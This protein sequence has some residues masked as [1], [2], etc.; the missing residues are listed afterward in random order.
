M[1][2][3]FASLLVAALFAAALARATPVT[4]TPVT[5]AHGMVVAAHPQA[6]AAGV[7]ILK[8]GGNA[9]DAAVAVAL[10]VGV[11]EPYGSGLGGK[12]MLVYYDAKSRTTTVVEAMDACG[13]ALDPDAYRKLPDDARS[14]G[15][16]SVC[17]PGLAAGLWTMHQKWGA[18]K[19]ADTVAPAIALARDG[20][21]IL[22][23]SRD[24]F[25]EQTKKLHRGDAELARLYLVDG[26]LPAV[27][28]KLK[29]ADLAHTMELLAAHG[30]DG[31][32]RGE[33]AE[34]IVAAAQA[35]GGLLTLEDFAGYEARLVAPLT[36]EFRG[37]RLACAPPPAAGPALFLTIMKAVET[38]DFGAGPLRT[39]ENLDRLGRVW[40]VAQPLA[41]KVVGDDPSSRAAVEK[42]FAPASI[43]SIRE[44][45]AASTP[46]KTVW[47][48]DPFADESQMAATTH[49][50][51][52]DAQGNI[53]CGTQSQSLHFGAGVIPPGTGV[54]LNDSM[55]NFSLTDPKS[56]NA[57]AVGRRPR[58][59]ISPTI[60]FRGEKPAFAIG[61]PGAARIPT[62]M[63]QGLLD[64]L[65][66]E[67]P[68]AEAIGDTRW[69]FSAPLRKEDGEVFEAERSF[70]AATAA[71]L[72][73]KGWRV[74][75]PEEP[76]HGHHFGGLNAIE[77]N[78]NGTLTGLADPRRTNVAAGY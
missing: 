2:R 65:V 76:G 51:V 1:I 35:G 69:H 6:A 48:A 52:V 62:A 74:V 55:S 75:L 43:R 38:D 44:K 70:P 9:A 50:I 56:P 57:L 54:V 49:W 10:A 12:L 7:E 5:A 17:V 28:T 73:A 13:S 42:L 34:K 32:Y 77:F 66:F 14:Y 30:R 36:M 67:R 23:K 58:S 53:A 47:L 39:A 22:P 37:Y 31:F 11:A 64:R 61:I 19:W 20:F 78:A 27:G 21:E 45:A 68:L 29:N 46:P 33:V 4:I 26:E 15:Y 60:V 40:R 41:A 8:R 3:T 25:A 16:T 59:T 18:K 72:R 71:A 63:L 24:F